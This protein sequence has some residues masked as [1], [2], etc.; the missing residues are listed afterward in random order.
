MTDDNQS[1]AQQLPPT[2]FDVRGPHGRGGG[3]GCAGGAVLFTSNISAPIMTSDKVRDRI[4]AA[5]LSIEALMIIES[6]T[7]ALQRAVQSVH[8][9]HAYMLAHQSVA[10]QEDAAVMFRDEEYVAQEAAAAA[11]G[12]TYAHGA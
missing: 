1:D 6:P 2:E 8:A 3:L 7:L 12:N 5:S 11:L 4:H 9:A 10:S